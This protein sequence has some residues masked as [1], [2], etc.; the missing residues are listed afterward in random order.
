VWD[1]VLDL[2]V[3]AIN[4][5]GRASCFTA[6]AAERSVRAAPAARAYGGS[7]ATAETAPPPSTAGH[8]RLHRRS[9]ANPVGRLNNLLGSAI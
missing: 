9:A 5:S 7:T 6:G 2:T 3:T 1:P 8:G 4:A